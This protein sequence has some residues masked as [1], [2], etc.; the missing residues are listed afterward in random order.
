MVVA[1]GDGNDDSEAEPQGELAIRTAAMPADTNAA[2]DIF[3]GW[4]LAQMDIA[5]GITGQRDTGGRV[6]TVGIES[7]SFHN[8]VFV[9]DVLCAYVDRLRTGTTSIT[10]KIE[11]WVVRHQASQRVKVTEGIFTY[12]AIAESGVPRRHGKSQSS[13]KEDK[14]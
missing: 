5:G 13:D 1:R 12:V 4:L 8:P 2:G 9:G 7:M 10:Y 3:G 6:A 14:K 11:A